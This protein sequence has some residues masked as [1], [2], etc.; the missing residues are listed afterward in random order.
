VLPPNRTTTRYQ[1]WIGRNSGASPALYAAWFNLGVELAASGDKAGATSAYQTVLALRPGFYPAAI[2]LGTLMEAAG[3]PEAA[4]AVWQQ[5]LQPEAA[6]TG[7]LEYRAQLAAAAGRK[8][9]AS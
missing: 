5:A 2:N 8:A 1:A 6:R 4:L 7:L 3:Q 9:E